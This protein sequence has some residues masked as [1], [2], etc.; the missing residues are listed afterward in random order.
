[1]KKIIGI[2][3]VLIG[4]IAACFGLKFAF[5]SA[6]ST[7]S[8]SVAIIGGADGPTAIFVAGKADSQS[9]IIPM[10]VGLLLVIAGV[11][12][13]IYSIQKKDE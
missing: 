5:N 11:I 8:Q 13:I 3:L 4:L 2:I 7:S 1:M 12:F 10:A 9:M 6:G